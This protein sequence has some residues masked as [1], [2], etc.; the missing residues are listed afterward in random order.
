MLGRWHVAQFQ[1]AGVHEANLEVQQS[2]RE[3]RLQSAEMSQKIGAE[4]EDCQ[5]VLVACP[6]ATEAQGARRST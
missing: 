6:N 1:P 2:A 5:V 4:M 3:M